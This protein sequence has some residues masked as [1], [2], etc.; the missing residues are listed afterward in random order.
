M[1]ASP[2]ALIVPTCAIVDLSLVGVASFFTS[3]TTAATAASMPRFRSIGF[4]PASTSLRPSTKIDCASTVAVVV[5][6]PALSLV[7]EA[8]S[9]TIWAPMFSSLP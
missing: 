8:T 4:A 3:A 7:F 5:P 9:R 2:L 6:S 1:V